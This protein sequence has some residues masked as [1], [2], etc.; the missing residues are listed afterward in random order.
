MAENG[1]P[2]T[3]KRY[4]KIVIVPTLYLTVSAPHARVT[5]RARDELSG[6]TL[7]GII[8]IPLR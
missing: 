7:S 3:V 1:P 4:H 8:V 6:A 2:L 5:F